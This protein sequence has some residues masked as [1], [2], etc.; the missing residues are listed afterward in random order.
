[1]HLAFEMME[2]DDMCPEPRSLQEIAEICDILD[3]Q[4]LKR[5]VEEHTS[6]IY[7]RPQMVEGGKHV[8]AYYVP[9]WLR[10]F[11]FDPNRSRYFYSTSWIISK[12]FH[13]IEEY[14]QS[15]SD[16]DESD[17]RLP[18]FVPTKYREMS[19]GDI[20]VLNIAV[21]GIS[22]ASR[23]LE[24]VRNGSDRNHLL[25]FLGNL[26]EIHWLDIYTSDDARKEL[27]NEIVHWLC[28]TLVGRFPI[29]KFCQLITI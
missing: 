27:A 25:R 9:R 22:D 24:H 2:D 6:L 16:F 14:L 13:A 8:S 23:F 28:T 10:G 3:R 12:C 11:F 18:F 20:V 5:F 21:N 7:A 17:T 19:F 4:L 1:M 26:S 15:N 29:I